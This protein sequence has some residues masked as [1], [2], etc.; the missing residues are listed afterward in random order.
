MKIGSIVFCTEQGLGLLAR[1]FYENRILS[2]VAIIRHSTRTNHYE[3]YPDAPRVG[4][5][6]SS[7]E[8]VEKMDAVLFFETPF[9]WELIPF[10][11][12]RNIPTI[13]MTMYECTP[14]PLPYVPDYYLTPSA[15]DAREFPDNSRFIRVPVDVP[16]RLRLQAKT[17]VHN[18]GNGGLRGRNGTREL[19]QAV[20]F[21]KSDMRLIVRAQGSWVKNLAKDCGCDKDERVTI[22]GDSIPREQLYEDGDVFVFPEKFNG[23]S[24]P[25]QEAFASGMVCMCGDRFPMNRWLP[26]AP[27]IPV[28]EM[29]ELRL[30][31]RFR[32]IDSAVFRP[33]DIAANID[34]WY[35]RDIES[36]SR[37]GLQFAERNSWQVLGPD[38]LRFLASC[39][40]ST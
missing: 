12:E 20:K 27:L 4:G 15:L 25:L 11:R 6:G 22:H 5:A 38:Y 18:A 23:L 33:E 19:L 3:W 35:G 28:H 16:W 17:F 36:L 34:E 29:S 2:D 39:K 14:Y 9:Y 30:S 7:K 32:P 13:L 1:D 8:F 24:L 10:C 31:R 21:I 37:A 40:S 26:R